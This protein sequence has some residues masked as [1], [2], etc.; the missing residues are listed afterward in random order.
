[1]DFAQLKYLNTQNLYDT[2]TG[3][4]GVR[5]VFADGVASVN[6]KSGD[7]PESWGGADST[8]A[9]MKIADSSLPLDDT[10]RAFDNAQ[11]TLTTLAVEL[12][13]AKA[14]LGGLMAQAGAIPAIVDD[15]GGVT[16]LNPF[17]PT[18]PAKAAAVAAQI[19]A[20]VARANEHDIAA[21]T[22]LVNG[23]EGNGSQPEEEQ[24]EEQEK[25]DDN[26]ELI[27]DGIRL[28][29]KAL[30]LFGGAGTY[31]GDSYGGSSL[32]SD[33]V[34]SGLGQVNA[35]SGAL[36][37]GAATYGGSSYGGAHGLGSAGGGFGGMSGGMGAAGSARSGGSSAMNPANSPG[38][39][40]GASTEGAA[41]RG[42]AGGG[43]RGGMIGGGR[44]M[45]S[46]SESSSSTSSKSWLHED[47]DPFTTDAAAPPVV[48]MRFKPVEED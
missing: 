33:G 17:D 18:A 35:G 3:C 24:Q 15:F 13:A 34:N 46:D 28:A 26:K 38:T 5:D 16:P 45:G 48:G 10:S 25:D 37:S 42:V 20:V 31:G 43:A 44:G 11:Q 41:N 32:A 2:A 36:A 40:V 9:V 47:C 21:R 19:A 1:M 22:K 4:A 12:D 6:K 23:H 8:A 39:P 27:R 30:S 14:D 29:Q 7:I